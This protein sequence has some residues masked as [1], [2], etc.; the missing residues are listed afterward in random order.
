[1]TFIVNLLLFIA[2]LS[3]LIFIHELG[4]FIFA[5]IF[6]VYCHEFSIGMGPAIFKKKFKWDK[7]TT[8]CIRMFPIGGFVSMAGESVDEKKDKN[9]GVNRS[10]NSIQAWKRAIIIIAGVVFNF[11]FAYILILSLS[12]SGFFPKDLHAE[13]EPYV[14]VQEDSIAHLAGL[15]SG[16]KIISLDISGF[17]EELCE[18]TCYFQTANQL[19]NTLNEALPISQ[20]D[21]Q[22]L[23]FQISRDG[24]FLTI[25]MQREFDVESQKGQLLGIGIDPNQIEP[26]YPSFFNGFVFAGEVYFDF[27]KQMI[28]AIGAIFSGS[29]LDGVGGPVQIFE[30][31]SQV[32]A[33]GVASYVWFVAIISINLAFFNLLPIPGLDGSRFFVSIFELISRKKVN[34]KVEGYINAVGILFLLSF[35]ILITIRDVVNLF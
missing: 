25:E 2:A 16:D 26:Y 34:P 14:F 12:W 15:E 27:L 3:V 11:I 31:S 10:I 9:I 29:G 4:H 17:R 20:G 5:K 24:E 35:M 32:A 8:Y 18:E 13:Y 33:L 23:D 30:V 7:E 6:K 21:N 22:T 1:M 28:G 19:I